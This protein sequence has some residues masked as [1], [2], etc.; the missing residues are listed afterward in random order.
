MSLLAGPFAAVAVLLGV[1]GVAKVV[2]PDAAAAALRAAGLP[3]RPSLVRGL[4]TF[5][6]AVAGLALGLGDRP[7]AVLVAAAYAAFAMF[8]LRLIGRRS[9]AGCGCFGQTEAPVGGIH[10]VA[11]LVMAAVAVGAAVWPAGPV[12]E[13]AADQPLLGLPF[14]V[15]TAVCAWLAYLVL[16]LLPD[17]QAATVG[18]EGRR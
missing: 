1:A 8:V 10:L 14:L 3:G 5:E 18:S 16:T 12:T 7:S 15:L 9:G 17:L 6:A 2:R 13:A 11:N 4:G